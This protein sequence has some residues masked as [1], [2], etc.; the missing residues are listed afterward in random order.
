[1]SDDMEKKVIKKK[2]KLKVQ[3]AAE[4]PQ[5]ETETRVEAAP[6][7]PSAEEAVVEKKAPAVHKTK[8]PAAEAA[9]APAPS[10]APV[11][12]APQAPAP[13]SQPQAHHPKPA[14]APAHPH[15][16]A[17]SEKPAG[18]IDHL[19][20]MNE[21][22]GHSMRP[23]TPPAR[24][25]GEGHP[26][27]GGAPRRFEYNRPAGGPRP[28]GGGDRPGFRPGPRPSGD[29]PGGFRPGGGGG[30][31]PATTDTA[32]TK[33][34]GR[35][36]HRSTF[37]AK[38]KSSADMKEKNKNKE[39]AILLSKLEDTVRKRNKKGEAVIP[40]EVEI[41]EIV[42]IAD[43][44]KK[45]N[46][47]A[48]EIIQKLFALG[49]TATINDNIDSDTAQIVA[50]EFGCKVNVKSL[51][52]E[53]EIKEEED[54]PESL[55][56]RFPVVTIMGHVDHGKT[57]LLDAIRN[58][59]VAAHETGGITQHI[60]A[61][62]VKTKKGEITFVDT[63][64]HEAF[65]AM[66]A[67]GANVTDIVILVVSAV[68]GAMP[69]TIEALNHAKLAKVPIIVAMNKMDLP[70]ANI[71]KC[72]QQLA[73]QNLLPED[74]GGDTLYI[75]V[76][77]V[78][79]TGINEL[80][81]AILLQAEMLELKANPDKHGVGFVIESKMDIGRGAVATVIV[82]NGSIRVGDV[83]V[84]GTTKGKV[85][86]M[87]DENGQKI[88]TALPSYPVEIMGF[89]E[90]PN[91]GDAFFVVDNEEFA[92]NIA[93]KRQEHKKMEENRELKKVQMQNAMDAM[94]STTTLKELKVVIKGDVQGSVEAIKSSL[95]KL[96]NEEVK[97][98]VIHSAVGAV[99]ESDVMLAT[100]T[101]NTAESG[102]MI[103]AFRVRVETTAKSKA[104]SENITIKRFNII[105]ELLDYVEGL[106][107]GMRT[108]EVIEHVIG[109]AEIKD[110]I[111]IK[112]VG[113]IAG[114]MVTS[115]YIRKAEKVRIFRDGTQVW[116]GKVN[117]LRRF[118]DDV[119]EVQEG[120][121][122]GVSFVNYEN[123]KKGDTVECFTQEVKK[124]L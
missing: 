16:P 80:L 57:S 89:D 50:S 69:Q 68:E 22:F 81:D 12:S 63:P 102:V 20:K 115:G 25:A 116:E 15:R 14:A 66:R 55:K 8:A 67:R 11:P 47:K 121:E 29:R 104:D 91:A 37:T 113:K 64:G 95:Q 79:K 24:P 110:I 35:N 76:S 49:V 45:M 26:A 72:K 108:P 120:F 84:V 41:A 39:E 87:F 30:G 86:G 70:G 21:K 53:I 44:A 19:K 90:V 105:Y 71:E 94:T 78:K 122:C 101:E 9:P 124:V 28:M 61:Y 114:C 38:G 75:P 4:K 34:L 111:K 1:M 3:P 32:A 106:M 17:A 88:Q 123:F 10:P 52:E 48:G 6:V 42:K 62:K 117:A 100:T 27:G 96:T 2:I 82:K 7:Q 5:E 77:A 40:T 36:K 83:F 118:K 54:T 98:T 99:L 58:S 60:G 85:R 103:L 59:S 51:K 33:D 18:T 97:V 73:D 23:S 119:S 31:R 13:S 56:P 74:W 65:T 109:N 92:K 46:L 112:D 43:L 107:K 93:T